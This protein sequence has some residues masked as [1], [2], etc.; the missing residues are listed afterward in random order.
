M[1]ADSLQSDTVAE[2]Q[3]TEFLTPSELADRR[4]NTLPSMVNHTPSSAT[5]AN[6]RAKARQDKRRAAAKAAKL[7]LK[8]KR[9][10]DARAA[11]AAR[12][13]LQPADENEPDEHES[14]PSP[15]QSADEDETETNGD[16]L[17]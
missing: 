12:S 15:P 5:D 2:L 4:L 14:S 9:R 7:A 17:V 8:A 6:L 11:K 1:V 13:F 16:E 10:S 3:G